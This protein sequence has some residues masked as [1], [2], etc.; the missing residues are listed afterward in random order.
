MSREEALNRY[1]RAL[2]HLNKGNP[3]YPDEYYQERMQ[4][5]RDSI[6]RVQE[7]DRFY[8]CSY[9]WVR[10]KDNLVMQCHLE[11]GHSGDHSGSPKETQPH[12]AG[13]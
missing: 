12:W 9:T 3:G 5:L 6:K 4:E 11:T 10:Y 8:E 1:N 13:R 2:D 7:L